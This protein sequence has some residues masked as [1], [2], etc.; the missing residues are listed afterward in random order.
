MDGVHKKKR[1]QMRNIKLLEDRNYQCTTNCLPSTYYFQ[2]EHMV[3]S[4]E[5]MDNTYLYKDFKV[6]IPKKKTF[7]DMSIRD[8]PVYYCNNI[9]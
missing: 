3:C 9:M 1:S 8:V 7:R 2:Y 6:E 4:F 5:V